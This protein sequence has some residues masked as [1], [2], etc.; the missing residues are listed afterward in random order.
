MQSQRVE[1]TRGQ[2]TIPCYPYC[3][4]ACRALGPGSSRVRDETSR[5]ECVEQGPKDQ[6]A[7]QWDML[8]GQQMLLRYCNTLFCI[9]HYCHYF[10]LHPVQAYVS[11]QW[12]DRECG[13]CWAV[14]HR[15]DRSVHLLQNYVCSLQLLSLLSQQP[16]PH[17]CSYVTLVWSRYLFCFRLEWKKTVSDCF[18]LWQRST[19]ST[20]WV[21][22]NTKCWY[23]H[24]F[25]VVNLLFGGC[26]P[27]SW[28][29]VIAHLSQHAL[30]AY[31]L[32]KGGYRPLGYDR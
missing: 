10:G 19:Q 22:E 17:L 28:N 1:P 16:F 13:C 12:V 3:W 7:Q 11:G 20:A 14:I 6:E 18:F 26:A 21:Q 31:K 8:K 5:G 25:S 23:A 2:C 29:K 15:S 27:C 9:C 30:A 24:S 4:W 32:P